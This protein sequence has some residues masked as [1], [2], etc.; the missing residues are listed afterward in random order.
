MLV[1]LALGWGNPALAGAPA[2]PSQ[3]ADRIEARAAK[4]SFHDLEAFGDAAAAGSDS[5]SLR[6]LQHV[7]TILRGQSEFD[8]AKSYN[9]KLIAVATRQHD[10]RYAAVGDLNALATRYDEGADGALEALRLARTR[11]TDWYARVV[12]DVFWARVQ[13]DKRDAGAALRL[14]SAA[15]TKIPKGQP[16]T[17]AAESMVW[18]MIGLSLMSL[19]DL[20][21]SAAAFERSQFEFADPRYPR[22]DFDAL[23]NLGRMA[24]D[25]GQEAT[26]AKLVSAHHKLTAVAD[27]TH[28][29]AWDANLCGLNAEAF[30][31]ARQVLWCFSELDDQ[32][33]GAEFLRRSILPMRAIAR[34]RHGDLA[35]ARADYERLKAY[36]AQPEVG[37]TA[38]ARLLEVEAELKLAEGDATTAYRLFRQYELK[39]RQKRAGEVYGSVRQVTGGLQS[40][41]ETARRDSEITAQAVRAQGWVIGLGVVLL[42]L[43]AGLVVLQ[44]QGAR[45]LRAAQARAEAANAAKS[46]FLATM[47]HEIRTPL[48]GVL[49][50]AQAMAIDRLTPRQ[51]DRLGVIRQSGEALLAILN[52]ILDLSKIEA[53][54]LELEIVEFD[55]T[56]VARGAYSAFTAIANKKGLS[57]ALDVQAAHGRY[58][59]DPSRLRQVL[60]NLISNALK[61]TEQGEIRVTATYEDGQLSIGVRDTGPGIAPENLARLFEKFDQ[62]DSSTTRRFG[63]TGLGLAICRE[64]AQLMGGRMIVESEL[65][66]GSRF[67]LLIPLERLGDESIPA[68]APPVQEDAPP[69]DLRV[70]AAE[71]N[72]VNQL[73]LKTL[74]HQLGIDPHVVEDG[75]AALDAWEGQPW[76]VILMDV[77]MPVMDGMTAS[78]KIRQRELETGRP[79]TPIIALTANAMSHQVKQYLAVGMDGH[80]AKP[81]EIAALYQALSQVLPGETDEA[82]EDQ[83]VA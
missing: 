56:E 44:R 60:Y 43:T 52:D 40:Q 34:A 73:V 35:G 19:N 54:K 21:A 32:L 11:Q 41:L 69:I 63:G 7:V 29:G 26:A 45:R 61:F 22:P 62:L 12:A 9:D 8:L 36:A 55:L 74:L 10:R 28:L 14:L 76:D 58:R 83:R 64:L 48:N 49:G 46:A 47:S 2:S 42:L 51:Q 78:T 1:A 71:D 67:Q 23:Y 50:M 6:R 33:T 82:D 75:Q 4:T 24:I 17:A 79:R 39:Q 72:A 53:G 27:L 66:L 65:G 5:E 57:F 25:L 37:P 81:I 68:P 13:I 38:G 70:L 77:Q 59:G 30:G 16:D 18:E 15:E 20:D 3:L 31:D 80:V